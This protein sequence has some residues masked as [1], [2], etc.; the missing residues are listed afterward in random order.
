MEILY[1][2]EPSNYE[3]VYST[4]RHEKF[5]TGTFSEI[6]K[7]T[8]GTSLT[9]GN[10]G[11]IWEHLGTFGNI[12]EH[13]GTFG[14]IWNTRNTEEHTEHQEHQEHLREHRRTPEKFGNIG[15]ILE[16]SG[17]SRNIGNTRTFW[18][19]RNIFRNI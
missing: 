16:H 8:S 17:T 15:N 10:T 13:L 2:E 9:I 3:T 6:D 7:Q 1:A 4:L 14:S 18:N 5:G 19:I 11:N 12:L